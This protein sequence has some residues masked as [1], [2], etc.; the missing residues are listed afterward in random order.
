MRRRLVAHTLFA[1][2]GVAGADI[3]GP[4]RSPQAIEAQRSSGGLAWLY[5]PPEREVFTYVVAG[6]RDPFLPLSPPVAAATRFHRVRLLGIISHHDSR[7]SIALIR[8]HAEEEQSRADGDGSG[9]GSNAGESHRA[10]IGD[11]IGNLRIMA[12]G[13]QQVVVALDGPAGTS[14]RIIELDS[15]TRS[16]SR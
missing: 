16:D 11:R 14:M 2:L 13:T 6:R 1:L 10:S 3:P 15:E 8:F 4:V 12:I 9:P 7:R 5:P